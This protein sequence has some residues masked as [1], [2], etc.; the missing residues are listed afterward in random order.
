MEELGARSAAPGGGSAA[1][2]AAAMGSGL[3]AMVGW[4]TYGSKKWENLDGTMR[5]LIGPLH[6]AMMEMIPMID[7]DTDAF[8]DYMTA[9]R[10]PKQTEEEKKIRHDAMQEGLKTAIRVPLKVMQI[11]DRCW[12]YMEEMAKHGNMNSKSDL[13]VGARSLEVGIWGAYRN[14]VINMNDVEDEEW[15]R[16]IMDEADSM[17]S[18]AKSKVSVVLETLDSRD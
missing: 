2:V 14:I 17:V 16:K 3:G 4:M 5:E 7:A 10:L 11:G 8:N 18:C 12:P 9:M 15:K 6:E 1:A 13:E